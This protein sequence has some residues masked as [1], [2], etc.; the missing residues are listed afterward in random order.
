LLIWQV[1][2]RGF[3]RFLRF[4]LYRHTTHTKWGGLDRTKPNLGIT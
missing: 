3:R 4:V 1:S 2:S